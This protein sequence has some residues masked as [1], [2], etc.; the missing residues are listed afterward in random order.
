MHWI[1]SKGGGGGV[2]KNGRRAKL[3]DILFQ[4]G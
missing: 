3:I 1:F 4:G 2:H